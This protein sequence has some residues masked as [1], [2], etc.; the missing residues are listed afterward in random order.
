[1]KKI[2]TLGIILTLIVTPIIS[3]ANTNTGKT[4]ENG[5]YNIAVG[6]ISNKSVEVAGSVKDNNGK[7]DIWDYRKCTSSKVL[8]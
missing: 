7:V 4:M 5:I 2:M 1:M 3:F 6:K 8:F